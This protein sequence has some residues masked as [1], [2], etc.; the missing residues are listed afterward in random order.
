MSRWGQERTHLRWL[1]PGLGLKRWLVL[2]IAGLILLVLG[3][4]SLS[5]LLD[6]SAWWRLWERSTPWLPV[7]LFFTIGC[8]LITLAVVN[9]SREL[10]SALRHVN[11]DDVVDAVWRNRQ[12]Q[13]GPPEHLDQDEDVHL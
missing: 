1:R 9:L 6:F 13:R 3:A 5:R 4:A 10:R 7:V 11:R 12:R 2:L 8:I